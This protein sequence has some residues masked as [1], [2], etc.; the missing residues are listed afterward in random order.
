MAHTT[1][2]FKGILINNYY[3]KFVLAWTIDLLFIPY[4][5]TLLIAQAVW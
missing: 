2:K 5:S 4:L 3:K 1:L